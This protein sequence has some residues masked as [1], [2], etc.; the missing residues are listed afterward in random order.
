MAKT[1]LRANKLTGTNEARALCA[2]LLVNG[3][4]KSNK[5]ETYRFMASA[6]V[7]FDD[8]CTLDTAERCAH[9]DAAIPAASERRVNVGLREWVL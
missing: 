9:C 8:Y 3:K 6:I 7:G 4:V 1:H 2:S 5:R